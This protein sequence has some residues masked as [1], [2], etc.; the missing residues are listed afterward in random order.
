MYGSVA[1]TQTQQRTKGTAKDVAEM[2][3]ISEYCVRDYFRKGLLPGVRLGGR[4]IFDLPELDRWF[5]E[6]SRAN[7]ER[8]E[9]QQFGKLRAV[10]K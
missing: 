2:L 1:M 10:G 9:V 8:K 4:I 7:V 6:R 3:G 5:K